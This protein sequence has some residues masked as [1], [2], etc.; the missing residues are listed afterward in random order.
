MKK[1]KFFY[2]L[3]AVLLFVGCESDDNEDS[4]GNI[5]ADFSFT[6]DGST[7]TFTNLSEG[8]T[9]YK[10][11]FG[12]LYF[13]S[14]EK[15]PVNTYD[16]VGGELMV[17]LTAYNDAG[18]QAYISKPIVAPVVIRANI[19]IDGDFEDWDELEVANE[20]SGS[21]K[22]MK[23][24]TKGANI[25]LYFEGNPDMMGIVDMLFNSDGDD[26]TGYNERWNIGGDFLF[27]GPPV[28]DGWGS[29]Y[30]HAG[31]GNGFSWNSIGLSGLG[32]Q[33]SG[34]VAIDSETSAIEMRIPK[35]FFGTVGDTIEF[36][37]WT[38]WGAE[39]YPEGESPIVI[40]IQ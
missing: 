18:Q 33:S 7:F 23:Y 35:S 14:T 1:L 4:S 40:E 28:V 34:V 19:D 30:S 13:Y 31:G 21:V 3:I 29:F 37:M 25:N 27:E 11:D 24:Y 32:F 9:S 20:F 2:Y 38:D 22:K 10:W 6:S 15:D 26:A 5:I 12:D 8:A 17:T 36:G 16:I 39:Y